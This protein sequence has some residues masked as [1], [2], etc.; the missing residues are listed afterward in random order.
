M[1]K[2]VEVVSAVEALDIEIS[3]RSA[4]TAERIRQEIGRIA[5]LDPRNILGIKRGALIVK[6]MDD[7]PEDARRCIQS[8]AQTQHG[9]R[10][11][12]YSKD[13]ALRLLADI[14]GMTR[15][16]DDASDIPP[17]QPEIGHDDAPA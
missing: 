2:H 1:L 10:I 6:D 17:A 16:K 9:L 15:P 3:K 7:M 12:F 13:A 4:I 14:E 5:F 8:V 11:T